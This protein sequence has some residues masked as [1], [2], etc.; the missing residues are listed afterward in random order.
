MMS[1]PE[2]ISAIILEPLNVNSR[3]FI[4]FAINN[5]DEDASGGTHWSLCVY[6]QPDNAF[7][8]FDSS[9]HFNHFPCES[10]VNI[11]KKCM[12]IPKAEFFQVDCL[13]QNNS[14]DCGIYVLCHA[15]LVCRTIMKSKSLKDVKKLNCKQIN[16]KRSELIEI[17]QSLKS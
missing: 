12:Q 11:M 7:Y 17:I 13:Q 4:I 1:N 5:N 16:V 9:S 10:L 6:S 15:D 2:E 3:S 14:Y 8:H